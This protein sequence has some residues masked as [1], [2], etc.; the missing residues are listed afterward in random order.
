MSTQDEKQP[1]RALR[2]DV[3]E[4]TCY[5][6]I[7]RAVEKANN[8]PWLPACCGTE[9]PMTTRTG[10]RVLYCWQPSTGRHAYL[11]LDT[12]LIIEDTDLGAYGLGG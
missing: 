1:T 10:A 5:E 6:R 3:G 4:L 11:D 2:P 12:D 7:R 9:E 8:G